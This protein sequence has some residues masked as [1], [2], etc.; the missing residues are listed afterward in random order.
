MKK[1]VYKSIVIEAVL[2]CA[3]LL[4]SCENFFTQIHTSSLL[5]DETELTSTGFIVSEGISKC[6]FVITDSVNREI[7]SSAPAADSYEF[8][9][10]CTKN[11]ELSFTET[12]QVTEPYEFLLV[13]G[14]EYELM[15]IGYNGVNIVSELQ[16]VCS[17]TVEPDGS[18][19]NLPVLT[20][21]HASSAHGAFKVTYNWD[22]AFPSGYVY[23][24]MQVRLL[25]MDLADTGLTIVSGPI[26]SA[27]FVTTGVN[28]HAEN[29]PIGK[30][31]LDFKITAKDPSDTLV[32]ILAY[33]EFVH[34][35]PYTTSVSNNADAAGIVH[36]TSSFFTIT[37]ETIKI[38]NTYIAFNGANAVFL[39]ED[40]SA[41]PPTYKLQYDNSGTWTDIVG[42]VI[43]SGTKRAVSINDYDDSLMYRLHA[44]IGAEAADFE[45]DN[46]VHPVNLTYRGITKNTFSGRHIFEQSSPNL[47]ILLYTSWSGPYDPIIQYTSGSG[48]KTLLPPVTTA[49]LSF[50][51]NDPAVYTF[52]AGFTGAFI[53]LCSVH[54]M[55][56]NECYVS[57]AGAL[58]ASGT[59]ANPLGI[60]AC[61]N[62]VEY[63]QKNG[64]A[65]YTI[66]IM[67]DIIL[68]SLLLLDMDN[69]PA[70]TVESS[71]PLVKRTLSTTADDSI[72]KITGSA[73][74][75]KLTVNSI[76]FSGGKGT[77]IDGVLCG[78]AA[79]CLSSGEVEFSNCTFNGGNVINRGG[80]L[81]IKNGTVTLNSCVVGKQITDFSGFTAPDLSNFSNKASH[82]GAI[83][84]FPNPGI[85]VFLNLTNTIIGYNH[86][87]YGGAVYIIGSGK[88]T[89][90]VD[91]N[92]KIY[93]N[94]AFNDGGALYITGTESNVTLNGYIG[95]NTANNGSAVYIAGINGAT[96]FTSTSRVEKN[97]CIDPNPVDKAVIYFHPTP[98]IENTLNLKGLI[99]GNTFANAAN[100]Y[101]VYVCN[102]NNSYFYTGEAFKLSGSDGTSPGIIWL[103]DN[104]I[105]KAGDYTSTGILAAI[106]PPEYNANI[107]QVLE[108]SHAAADN[109]RFSVVPDG[110]SQW[111]ID[112][113]GILQTAD[114]VVSTADELIT[115]IESA[116]T[117]TE[118]SI[119]LQGDIDINTITMDADQNIKLI[120][121]QDITITASVPGAEFII[122]SHGST[123][124]LGDEH[125]TITIKGTG[126]S[127]KGILVDGDCVLN[128]VEI[129]NFKITEG[130]YPAPLY[131]KGN[132]TMNG[133]KII[134]NWNY[135]TGGGAYITA[136]GSLTIVETDITGNISEQNGGGVYVA[137]GGTFDITSGSIT[138]NTAVNGGGVYVEN[139]GTFPVEDEVYVT[140]N[141]A[142]GDGNQITRE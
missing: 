26:V 125:H 3:V 132:V 57:A 20:M 38:F 80:A 45:F 24:S 52:Y 67:D 120:A 136:G 141:T 127:D 119:I 21:R 72:I 7:I 39:W 82:G 131:V 59:Q 8:Y 92:S 32:T 19:D 140:D 93:G 41:S 56:Q 104:V 135:L 18:I 73:S 51:Q 48:S 62:N 46:K 118:V 25:T 97:N 4:I 113:N 138:G 35:K 91:T 111:Y 2:I 79:A 16:N 129:T 29:I 77:I 101:D 81:Y 71:D 23:D 107:T 1:S 47:N 96:T 28:I 133:G 64:T 84:V 123:L 95:Y 126:T 74:S 109:N 70:T 31:I 98:S 68:S 60:D 76:T 37:P 55:P 121:S 139:G 58:D 10:T 110:T 65:S 134:N 22:S 78:G 6:T 61:I 42:T 87:L 43:D 105:H 5:H 11:P 106:I 116:P 69:L 44:A 112:N 9:F 90:T 117:G 14:I 15:I 49:T 99:S 17:F 34:I 94:T 54:I 53:E 85:E 103:G 102:K 122:V 137:T 66:K 108:T 12:K 13:V 27:D 50:T 115:S 40:E 89:L 130:T 128:N 124:T 100:S 75:K 63:I 36:Y 142:S 30:Y 88:T 83:A 114:A 86:A 33:K